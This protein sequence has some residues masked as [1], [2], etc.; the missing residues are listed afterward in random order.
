MKSKGRNQGFECIKCNNHSKSKDV[1]PISRK[2]KQKLYLPTI[3]SQ[4]HLTR[5][6]QRQGKN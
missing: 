2:I 6:Y 1:E 5:P 4:R 3:S